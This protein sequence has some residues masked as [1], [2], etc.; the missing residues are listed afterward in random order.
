MHTDYVYRSRQEKKCY[1]FFLSTSPLS[2]IEAVLCFNSQ[3]RKCFNDGCRSCRSRS[4]LLHHDLIPGK[5]MGFDLRWIH[6][7]S[8]ISQRILNRLKFQLETS[9]RILLL[10]TWKLSE[11]LQKRTQ[12]NMLSST[13]CF[14]SIK[15]R[16]IYSYKSTIHL[17]QSLT[18][19]LSNMIH[20]TLWHGQVI[21]LFMC[22]QLLIHVLT[23]TVVQL[24]HRWSYDMDA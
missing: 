5:Q 1:I 22:M 15:I 11:T 13:L 12:S 2:Q 24:N 20:L 17:G 6:M 8:L 23:P 21:M 4:G 7:T 14:H 18:R 19:A 3:R 10:I 16:N 9:R